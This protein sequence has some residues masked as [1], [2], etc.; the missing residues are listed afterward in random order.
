MEWQLSASLAAF[1]QVRNPSAKR[2][3]GPTDSMIDPVGIYGNDYIF[4]M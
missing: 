3:E 2:P 4:Y 1:V